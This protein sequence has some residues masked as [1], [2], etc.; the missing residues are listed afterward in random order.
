MAVRFILPSVG[1]VPV[2][3]PVNGPTPAMARRDAIK[4]NRVHG[5]RFPREVLTK[6]PCDSGASAVR[7]S[8]GLSVDRHPER[9]SNDTG[10]FVA[11]LSS[12]TPNRVASVH[13]R[14]TGWT[15]TMPSPEA[16][17][18][19]WARATTSAC[20]SAGSFPTEFVCSVTVGRSPVRRS[21][22]ACEADRRPA[23]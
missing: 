13:K 22:R 5:C 12:G 7:S 2:L 17:A 4:H 9:G 14:V 19:G 20:V 10:D 8:V 16:S 15:I 23:S 21:P 6:W 3:P 1:R 11:L 18:S